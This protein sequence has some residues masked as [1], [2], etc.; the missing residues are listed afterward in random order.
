M[1]EAKKAAKVK[2]DNTEM[3]ETE[4]EGGFFSDLFWDGDVRSRH[5]WG[6]AILAGVIN[7]GIYL[8]GRFTAEDDVV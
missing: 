2:A 7:L 6:V 5:I 1:A 8:F 4:E 3:V